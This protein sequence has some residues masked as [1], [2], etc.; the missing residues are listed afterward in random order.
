MSWQA[1]WRSTTGGSGLGIL[2]GNGHPQ[3]IVAASPGRLYVDL[4]TGMIFRK[5]GGSSTVWGWYPQID[6]GDQNWNMVAYNP[7]GDTQGEWALFGF[8]QVT[9]PVNNGATAFDNNN[10]WG[11]FGTPALV[12][13]QAA[14]RCPGSSTLGQVAKSG[15]Y[16]DFWALVASS[17]NIV[18]VGWWVGL[19]EAGT[20]FVNDDAQ[21]GAGVQNAVA[22]F[23]YYP[24]AAGDT[25]WVPVCR[26]DVAAAGC[27]ELP[28]VNVMAL[29]T[30][31]LLRI[32]G[33]QPALGSPWSQVLFSINNGAEVAITTG[34]PLV[35]KSMGMASS[36]WTTVNLTKE[37]RIQKIVC[38]SGN[39]LA[40]F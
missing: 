19:Y 14:V 25:G 12:G 22:A 27:T 28:A 36:M 20:D 16:F 38:V 17:A 33:L 5:R 2:S 30:K 10:A 18:D 34:I 8:E 39:G 23:R 21:G 32:R 31:M 1:L 3:G 7:L 40:E 6:V 4:L 35:N 11:I 9:M 37:F 13:Q 15:V 24:A 29:N 26:S